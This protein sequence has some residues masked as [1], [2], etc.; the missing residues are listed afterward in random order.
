MLFPSYKTSCNCPA[1][2]GVSTLEAYE[3][4]EEAWRSCGSSETPSPIE[5]HPAYIVIYM[6]PIFPC[7]G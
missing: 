7:Y 5:A 2:T 1:G 3:V 6:L 4:H